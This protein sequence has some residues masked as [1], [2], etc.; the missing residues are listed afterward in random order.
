[1]IKAETSII[2]SASRNVFANLTLEM[3][4]FQL[5]NGIFHKLLFIWKNEPT[6]ILNQFNDPFQ[7]CN[8]DFIK[9]NRI[10]LAR[11]TFGE[12]ILY[13]DLGNTCFSFIGN[14]DKIID[15]TDIV[16]NSMKELGVVGSLTEEN[17]IL[18]N[19]KKVSEISLLYLKEKYIQSGTLYLNTNLEKMNSVLNTNYNF[20]MNKISDISNLSEIKLN[21][22]HET[23]CDALIKNFQNKYGQCPILHLDET[24]I[25]KSERFK[26]ILIFSIQILAY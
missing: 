9:K 16:V 17:D 20:L 10:K 22:S 11:R 14:P 8:F 24:D 23:F 26:K 12:K 6:V 2:F 13:Q 5:Y 25:L 3:G 15:D 19:R 21:L 7:I 1:M 18:V 4:N